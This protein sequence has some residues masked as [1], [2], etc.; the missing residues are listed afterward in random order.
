MKRAVLCLVGL[1]LVM[2]GMSVYADDK[3]VSKVMK[4][5]FKGDDSPLAKVL[6]GEASAQDAKGL[7]KMMHKIDG[8]EAPKGDQ[9]A[10]AEKVAELLAAMDAV[11]GGDTSPKSLDRLDDASSCKACHDPHKPKKK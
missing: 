6:E 9:D 11:A 3:I 2:G 4:E 7:A 5:G 1:S 8:I 10:Y